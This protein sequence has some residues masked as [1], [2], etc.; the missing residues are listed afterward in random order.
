MTFEWQIYDQFK[1]I[2]F[3]KPTKCNTK[4][5]FLAEKSKQ[6]HSINNIWEWPTFQLIT[7]FTFISLTIN[8]LNNHKIYVNHKMSKTCI[9][10]HLFIGPT[11]L[12][13]HLFYHMKQN[14]NLQFALKRFFRSILS[15]H[16]CKNKNKKVKNII[17]L[18]YHSNI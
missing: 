10:K 3:Y 13:V 12:L 11:Q 1:L 4:W 6:S 2:E 18:I 8:K 7:L 9:P 17:K 16:I 15:L 5:Q 14:K